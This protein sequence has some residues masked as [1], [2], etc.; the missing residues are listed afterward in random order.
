LFDVGDE[1]SILK[2]QASSSIRTS[3]QYKNNIK[4]QKIILR[5]KP[6]VYT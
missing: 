6:A 1:A 3:K 5:V 4:T 2:M